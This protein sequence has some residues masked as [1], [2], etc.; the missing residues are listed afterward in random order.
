MT[1]WQLWHNAFGRPQ[2]LQTGAPSAVRVRTIRIWLQT[3]HGSRRS[4][5]LEH[6][7]Q[8]GVAVSAK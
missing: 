5:L 3:E 8:R 2:L 1:R 6:G 4:S 7:S